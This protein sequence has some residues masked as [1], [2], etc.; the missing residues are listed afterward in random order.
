MIH[1]RRAWLAHVASLLVALAVPS[2]GQGQSTRCDP[3]EVEVRRLLFRG[4]AAFPDAELARTIVTTR[5]SWGRRVSPIR[6]GT[7]RC[8]D[9]DELVRDRLRLI[10]Y[11]RAR[12]Y[13]DVSVEAVT[14]QDRPGAARVEFRISE[15]QPIILRELTVTGL[16]TVPRRADLIRGLP[17]RAGDPLDR[18]RLEA[19]RDTL[20]R[21]LRN[22][23]Y[24]RAQ[25]NHVTVED[26]ATRSAW[27]TLVVTVGPMTRIGEIQVQASPLAGRKQQ[28][29]DRTVRRIAGVREGD[30]YREGR[31]LDAQRSL[32]LTDAY[33]QVAVRVDTTMSA[34]SVAAL[35]LVV[36]EDAMRSAEV[37]G[38]YGTLDCFRA[39]GGLTNY[40]FMQGARR[41]ELRA[42]VSKIGVGKPLGGAEGLCPQARHDPYS[43]RLNYYAGATI[44]QPALFR[45]RA[46]PSLT[47]FS[48]RTSE[49]KAF[50]R[51]TNI[52]GIA[53]ID[54]RRFRRAPVTFAYQL[55]YGRTEAQPALFC[56]VFNRCERE[57]R[58]RLQATQRLGTVSV[59]AG[60][61]FADDPLF[62]RKGGTWRLEGRHASRATLADSGLAF[63]KVLGDFARYWPFGSSVIAVRLRAG[64]VFSGGFGGVR[65]F[66]PPEERLFAGGPTTVRGFPQNELGSAI[67]VA[68]RFDTVV[69]NAD[70]LFTTVPGVAEYRR[71]VPVGGNTMLVGNLELR[72][73]SPLLPNIF[74]LTLFTDAGDVWNRGSSDVFRGMR[75][76]TTPGV[77]LGG[78]TPLGLIRVVVGYNPYNRERGPIYYEQTAAEGGGLPCVSPGNA[79]PV[80]TRETEVGLVLTQAEGR[81]PATFIPSAA[82]SFGGRLNFSFALG[83]AF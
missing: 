62:P 61:T 2:V 16:E 60:R 80:R 4:N 71:A 68:S 20:L 7:R 47:V 36:A 69:V 73:R 21:R 42:R 74:Q 24:P 12:G 17:I 83:Q 45:S 6:F 77:Q 27:D 40:N 22:S 34:D 54:A 57:E 66:I 72:M 78:V 50:L 38:G 37:G 31:L 14:E 75:V 19:A 15:G 82:R 11:Y 51:T 29:S 59:I 67:Y 3:G 13:P 30:L 28:I 58:E 79:L 26:R 41:L 8:L 32:Y 76:K 63:N 35:T 10:V 55:D 25:A 23:G 49:F 43:S 9:R 56:A 52:G 46:I 1:G 44:R 33:R 70:T 64:G 18:P 81:C 39:T 48:S 65:N 53:T 5:S